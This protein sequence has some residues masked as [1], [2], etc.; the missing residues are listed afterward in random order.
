MNASGQNP[1]GQ[2]LGTE[3]PE[4][5]SPDI[6]NSIDA[7]LAARHQSGPVAV[8]GHTYVLRTLTPIEEDW[9]EAYAADGTLVRVSKGR[10]LTFAAAA[11]VS[12]DHAPVETLFPTPKAQTSP[13]AFTSWAT[14]R[15]NVIRW[16][17][18]KH[19]QFVERLYNAYLELDKEREAA[20]G[21][22]DPLPE[23]TRGG[24]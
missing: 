3:V 6:L 11:L 8:Y 22:L 23:T 7:E 1:I 18:G 14:T 19:P 2:T 20:L 10:A 21:Q 16:L 12:I 13:D 17:G 5:A 24:P 9:A 15:R 4:S